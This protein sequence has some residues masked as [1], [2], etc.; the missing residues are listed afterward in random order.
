MPSDQEVMN[1]VAAGIDYL[2]TQPFVDITRLGVMG[3]CAGGTQTYL[4]V[5]TL[6]AFRA[7]VPHYGAPRRMRESEG[8]AEGQLPTAFD[9]ADK[10]QASL[11]IVQGEED[12]AIPIQDVHDYRDRLQSLGKEVELA[13][14]PGMGHA[15]TIRGGRSYDEA[16]AT[17]AWKRTVAHFRRTLMGLP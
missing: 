2:R 6:D 16:S 11:L 5:S 17:D 13:V 15:F 12:R 14:Y 1:D 10:V 4:A 3:F 8:P 7:G 9:M